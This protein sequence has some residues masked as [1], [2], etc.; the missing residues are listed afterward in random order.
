MYIFYTLFVISV[1]AVLILWTSDI[2]KNEDFKRQ[3]IAKQLAL[4]LD[5]AV[6]DAK[7]DFQTEDVNI[8]IDNGKI[9]V[10][11]KLGFSY[12]FYSPYINIL[13]KKQDKIFLLK[14]L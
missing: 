11:K 8:T 10:K 9:D 2:A 12:N 6:P 13:E 3:V 5:A 7:I 14:V 4:V 1:L